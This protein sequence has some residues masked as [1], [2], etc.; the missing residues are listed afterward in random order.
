MFVS[1]WMTAEVLTVQ[2]DVPLADAARLMGQKRIRRLPVLASA[3]VDAPLVGIIS[4]TDVLHA[5][6]LNV[7][8]FTGTGTSIQQAGGERA[9]TVADVMTPNPLTTTADAPIE[10][11]ASLM[12]SRKIGA[13]P[14][15]R[16]EQLVGMITESD[17]F[18]AFTSMFDLSA[19]GAR[20]TFDI[21]QGEDVLP[22]IAE[23]TRKHD[24][25]VTSF[26]ALHDHERPVCVVRLAGKDID[27]MLEDVWKSHHRVESV[28]RLEE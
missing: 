15:M 8:P 20:I 4:S 26:V 11:A 17:I 9:L 6:P 27:A 3:D 1:M 24:L 25:Q 21:S 18:R 12:R 14:V 7:N 19:A 13:L 28:I 23:L 5:V 2:P 10:M 16:H 22:L